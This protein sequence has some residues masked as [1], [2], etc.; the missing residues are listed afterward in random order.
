VKIDASR[1]LAFSKLVSNPARFWGKVKKTDKCWVWKATKH[2][3]GYGMFGL[4]YTMLQAHRVSY[5]LTHGSIPEGMFVC[6]KCDNRACVNPAHLFLGT[7]KD[8]TED[9]FAK[10]RARQ[11]RERHWNSKLTE[12]S[13]KAIRRMWASGVFRQRQIA[14][15]FGVDRAH[16][17]GIVNNKFWKPGRAVA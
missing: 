3:T 9:M 10:R 2:R 12:K 7:A 17:S 16:I 11:L 1:T 8:N 15:E 5:Q 13:V 6:H 14:E 4:D